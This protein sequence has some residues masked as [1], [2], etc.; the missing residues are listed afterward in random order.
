MD[1][2]PARATHSL[3]FALWP[4]EETRS[5]IGAAS[6]SLQAAGPAHGRWIKPA[7]YH[8]TL[9]YLGAHVQV[10]ADL[11]ADARAVGDSV[12]VGAF[13]C[14]LDMAGSFANRSIPWW[15]GCSRIPA[16]MT[17]LVDRIAEG[18]RARGR[19]IKDEASFVAHVT[20][21]R[22]AERML[23]VSAIAP[24]GWHVDEF[25]LI[26]SELGPRPGYTIVERW[27]LISRR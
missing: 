18:M 11:I 10:P 6:R 4:G 15:V 9:R 22:D 27:P 1:R 24:I 7:R 20:V 17:E 5:R 8:L 23:P 26:D 3:F 21:L 13:D 14:A 16:A 12:R 25:V 2:M 19:P